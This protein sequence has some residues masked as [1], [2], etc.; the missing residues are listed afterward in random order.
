MPP[1][2]MHFVAMSHSPETVRARGRQ[3]F[4]E[5]LSG[6]SV[7]LPAP[8]AKAA[9]RMGVPLQTDSASMPLSSRSARQD[10][11]RQQKIDRGLYSLRKDDSSRNLSSPATLVKN[12]NGRVSA[13]NDPTT[14]TKSVP[15]CRHLALAFA[16][17]AGKKREG[18]LEHMSVGSHVEA[19]FHEKLGAVNAR[20][21]ELLISTQP[22]HRHI[23]TDEKLGTYLS[24]LA[25]G[26]PPSRLGEPSEVNCLMLTHNHAMA[27]HV[28][29][30]R[31]MSGSEYY[32]VRMYDPNQTSDAERIVVRQ[33]SDLEGLFSRKTILTYTG[34]VSYARRQ[35]MVALCL[36]S[37]HPPVTMSR[38]ETPAS[39]DNMFLAVQRGSRLDVE[40]MMSVDK[41]GQGRPGQELI[42]GLIQVSEKT[43]LSFFNEAIAL[44]DAPTVKQLVVWALQADV[45]QR[46]KVQLF[47]PNNNNEYSWFSSACQPDRMEV[48]K[49]VIDVFMT[50]TALTPMNKLA[51]LSDTDCDGR[52]VLLTV[53][54]HGDAQAIRKIFSLVLASSGL[55]KEHTSALL[56]QRGP[57][58]LSLL[59][60]GLHHDDPEK[61]KATCQA[62]L[63][64]SGMTGTEK[65]ALLD[66]KNS[67][68]LSAL[69][70]AILDG[71]SDKVKAL[72]EAVLT[73]SALTSVEKLAHFGAK[74][75]SGCPVLLMGLRRGQAEAVKTFCDVVLMSP[76]LTR[77]QKFT[78]FNAA[79]ATA[80]PV[81]GSR[82]LLTLSTWLLYD[83]PEMVGEVCDVLL[84]PSDLTDLQRSMLLDAKDAEGTTALARGLSQGDAESVE[85][86]VLSIWKSHLP[87]DI[88]INLLAAKG[89]GTRLGW[90]AARQQGN[91]ETVDAFIGLVEQFGRMDLE[92]RKLCRALS[93]PGYQRRLGLCC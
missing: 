20:F 23:V 1:V 58:G 12:F 55:A 13:K 82:G 31:E 40:A 2:S 67:D 65:L 22:E 64:T 71:E 14:N 10:E 63:E 33:P 18:F 50:S 86:F 93:V 69:L 85:A 77:E 35:P 11:N 59:S 9:G 45:T 5:P 52:S 62:M 90:Q 57:E 7:S 43:G 80:D 70:A 78:L 24:A 16:D 4:A 61:A 83:K 53:L 92:G 84:Q 44:L 41:G 26:L 36:K 54:H 68:A 56:E 27:V 89:D 15:V 79:D 46:D 48:L 73:S 39:A 30:K 21:E 29:R 76:A 72:C 8:E 66:T 91:T 47:C 25:K 38:H 3:C 75:A 51:L 6:R 81:E 88:K 60:S 87:L 37:D 32:A 19:Y 49:T 28:Q 17:Q 34:C 42:K 74:D